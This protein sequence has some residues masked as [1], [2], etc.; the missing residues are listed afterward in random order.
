MLLRCRCGGRA[1]TTAAAL[2]SR[3]QPLTL[4]AP[5]TPLLRQVGSG[6]AAYTRGQ[7]RAL[8]ASFAVALRA[9]GVAPGSVVTL[10]EPNT[11]EHVVAFLGITLARCVAAPLNQGYTSEAS[12]ARERVVIAVVGGKG[13]TGR[14]RWAGRAA[15]RERCWVERG[16]PSSPTHAHRHTHAGVQILHARRRQQAAAGGTGGV[17]RGRGAARRTLRLPGRH[18]PC[19]CCSSLPYSG[20]QGGAAGPGGGHSPRGRRRERA[21][22]PRPLRRGALPPHQRHYLSPQGRPP[23]PRQP[24]GLADQHCAG[25]GGGGCGHRGGGRWRVGVGGRRVVATRA[26]ARL[27]RV[28]APSLPSPHPSSSPHSFPSP[29]PS[30]SPHPRCCCC[31]CRPTSSPRQTHPCSSCPCSTCTA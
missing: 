16:P 7:L 24:G 10:A 13:M 6:G 25:A 4:P 19:S 27:A 28:L 9:S 3:A 23:H 31:C 11:V 29:H 15:G 5:P 17:P 20:T 12:R 26:V 14:G 8:V 18:P 30:S 2:P 1:R 21:R 22:P